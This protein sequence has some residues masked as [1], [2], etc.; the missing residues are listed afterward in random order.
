[1]GLSEKM[2]TTVRCWSRRSAMRALL[3]SVGMPGGESVEMIRHRPRARDA[4]HPD[5]AGDRGRHARVHLGRNHQTPGVCLSTRGPG[6]AN[7]VNGVAHAWMDRCPLIVITDQYPPH[8]Y[9]TGLRQRT[10][11]LALYTP[12]T[13]WN[14]TIGAKTVRQRD[15]GAPCASPPPILPAPCSSTFPRSRR[16]KRPPL[17]QPSRRCC[18]IS[19]P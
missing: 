19:F 14:S 2:A 5:E 11:H 9:E 13:K 17:L 8:T 15:P 10:N 12:I 1:M 16:P 3:L 18:P 7:M 4:L 6:A